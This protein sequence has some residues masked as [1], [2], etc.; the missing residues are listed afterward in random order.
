[1]RRFHWRNINPSTQQARQMPSVERLNCE[2]TVA[3]GQRKM[4][5]GKW[6][7]ATSVFLPLNLIT[8]ISNQFCRLKCFEFMTRR[9]SR[10]FIM[11]VPLLTLPLAPPPLPLPLQL[12]CAALSAFFCQLGAAFVQVSRA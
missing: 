4:G 5:N 9:D 10:V 7:T 12:H 1:M 11:R 6:E 3:V 2:Q 8:S